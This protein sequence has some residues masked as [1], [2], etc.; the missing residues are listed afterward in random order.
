[1]FL[2]LLKSDSLSPIFS[3]EHLG[4]GKAEGGDA[5]ADT[6]TGAA[7]D[8]EGG[9]DHE[10]GEPEGADHE[11][12]EEPEG[13]G[14]AKKE[15]GS[16]GGE[17]KDEPADESDVKTDANDFTTPAVDEEGPKSNRSDDDNEYFDSLDPEE[18][19]NG[20]FLSGNGMGPIIPPK[21]WQKFT[22]KLD[23]RGSNN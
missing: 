1:M 22:Q 18:V 11:N 21:K 23:F 9:D 13:D 20:C 7:D 14:E 10:G 17:V 3:D 6:E 8:L 16:I 19:V 5:D 2:L 12:K 15:E 4:E